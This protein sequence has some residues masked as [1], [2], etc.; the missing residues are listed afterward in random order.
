MEA[1]LVPE[2]AL[3]HARV[4]HVAAVWQRHD[5]YVH[6]H[7]Y[8]CVIQFITNF[9]MIEFESCLWPHSNTSSSSSSVYCF[10]S[11][12]KGLQSICNNITRS[13]EFFYTR[14]KVTRTGQIIKKDTEET[15]A[16]VKF[17]E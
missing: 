16:L 12:H 1:S 10:L 9:V 3:Q 17:S 7:A 13:I 4:L 5:E 2:I 6:I 8:G 15:H 14:M 11:K